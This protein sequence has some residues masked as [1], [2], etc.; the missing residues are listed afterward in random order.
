MSLNVL[1]IDDEPEIRELVKRTIARLGHKA[2]LACQGLEAIEMLKENPFDVIISDL[3][4]PDMD[5]YQFFD[6]LQ[7]HHPAIPF[8][9]LSG[10][11]HRGDREYFKN[12]YSVK[13]FLSKPLDKGKLKALLDDIQ[14]DRSAPVK[15]KMI[16][17][18]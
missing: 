11:S 8:I 13:E 3:Q 5:G 14:R 17:F 2:N 18:D 6:Y 12:L 15:K 1:I 10:H 16:T 4:M 7:K 9:I